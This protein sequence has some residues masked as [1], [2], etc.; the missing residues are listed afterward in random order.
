MVQIRVRYL[1]SSIQDFINSL[2]KRMRIACRKAIVELA[3]NGNELNMP[4][5]KNIGDGLFELRINGTVNI[6]IIYAFKQNE[7]WILNVFKKEG[8]KI[9]KKEI[10]LAKK[11][12][13]LFLA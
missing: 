4:L 9:P 2:D 11:R 6:R 1:S 8:N 10:E 12:R 5:S 3:N 13:N 7:A